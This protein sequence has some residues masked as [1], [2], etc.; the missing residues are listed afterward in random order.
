MNPPFSCIPWNCKSTHFFLLRRKY[1]PYAA[2]YPLTEDCLV[3]PV[4]LAGT[5]WLEMVEDVS[6]W[7]LRVLN[8]GEWDIRV[9]S[10]VW[11]HFPMIQD[12]IL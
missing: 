11:K 6:G 10:W 9:S 8:Q 12:L 5:Y 1:L 4:G 7:I 2:E 3:A